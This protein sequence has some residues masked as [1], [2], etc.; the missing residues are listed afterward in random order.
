MDVNRWRAI[1]VGLFV[2]VM[3]I[4]RL[5]GAP[6][7]SLPVVGTM[8]LWLAL[9]GVWHSVLRRASDARRVDRLLTVISVVDLTLAAVVQQ[10]ADGTWY[11]GPTMFLVVIASCALSLQF[12]SA[13]AATAYGAVAY[14]TLI[15][16]EVAGFWQADTSVTAPQLVGRWSSGIEIV[17]LGWLAMFAAVLLFWGFHDRLQRVHRRFRQL[18]DASPYFIFTVRPDGGLTSA[19]P[20]AREYGVPDASV[21][22]FSAILQRIPPDD[23]DEIARRVRAAFAGE[24]SQYE[25]RIRRIDGAER[26]LRVTYTPT[27]TK[28]QRRVLVMGADIT[29]E[30]AAAAERDRLTRE[31][32]S[33][34]RMRLVGQLVSGVAHELNNPL[35]AILNYGELLR[36]EARPA[37]DAEAL[38]VMHAQ[39]MRAR[40][41]V[42]DLLLVARASNE[43]P[44]ETASVDD[45]VRRALQPM[46]AKAAAAGVHL[47]FDLVGE[48]RPQR[49]DVAGIEQVVTNLVS[50][51][52]DA[53]PQ[54]TV[55][56][57]V[58]ATED[59]TRL[60]VRDTGAGIPAD[61][62]ARLFEPFFTT[63]APGQGT[64]LGLAVTRGIVEQHGGTIRVEHGAATGGSGAHF[65]VELP[66]R[67]ESPPEVASPSAPP[68]PARS[69]AAATS[70]EHHG[71]IRVAML[72][73]DEQVVRSPMAR[74]LRNAG[75]VVIEC[76]DGE[77]ALAALRDPAT[78]RIDAIIS[79]IRMPGMDGPAFYRR[80]RREQPTLATR[81][82]F[83]TGDTASEEVAHFLADSGCPV[84]EKPF[85]LRELVAAVD[86]LTA[87]PQSS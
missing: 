86:Q 20:V 81:M 36:A 82:L 45:V 62:R 19:N 32:E 28:G 16:G 14:A 64:G 53:A 65:V 39:A 2:A 24:S 72:V 71:V 52:I 9:T 47:Q 76:G 63:K 38:E 68:M 84:I 6:W 79:D 11:L 85:T 33:A 69:A 10:L 49:L 55:R 56:V 78:P 40:A 21:A 13:L 29:D 67:I 22:P 46:A 61:V 25:H 75:W 37:Q 59:G 8:L 66:M 43:R 5:A 60:D 70:A 35:A 15:L 77:A 44:R 51:A 54:G 74:A 48:V 83:A 26:W 34:G 17:V 57:T 27:G 7:V 4:F 87:S 23:A 73:D 1:T 30:R 12:W 18:F 31:I 41:I 58:A 50:N 80:L 42:R 3:G